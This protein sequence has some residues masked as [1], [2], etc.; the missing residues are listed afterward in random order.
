MPLSAVVKMQE[1]LSY[2][3]PEALPHSPPS[4][5]SEFFFFLT[6]LFADICLL[7]FQPIALCLYLTWPFSTPTRHIFCLILV[8]C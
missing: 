7:S 4:P 5:I 6:A 3:F 2:M 8:A 1:F